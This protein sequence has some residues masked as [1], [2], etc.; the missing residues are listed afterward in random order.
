[1][2]LIF[3]RRAILEYREALRHYDQI[4]FQLGDRFVAAMDSAV[5]RILADPTSHPLE[6]GSFR[7]VRLKQFPYALFFQ[8][9]ADNTVGVI[10]VAH[11][12]RRPGYWR[13]RRFG[14]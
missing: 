1:M 10:S 2:E 14:G 11:T 6:L 7:C 12:S 4:S 5:A 8:V 13:H 3:H 9:I